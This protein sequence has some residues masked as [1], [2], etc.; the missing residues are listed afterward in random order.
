MNR[1]AHRLFIAM[2]VLSSFFCI[3]HYWY[4]EKSAC[5]KVAELNHLDLACESPDLIIFSYDRPMQLYALLESI[6]KHI[7]GFASIA[8][9]Y[10][11]S[12]H[13][14]GAGYD[15]VKNEFEKVHFMQQSGNGQ[16]DFK[17]LLLQAFYAGKSPYVCFGVDDIIVKNDVDL[18]NCVRAL[19]KHEAYGFYLRLGTHLTKCYSLHKDQPL[20]TTMA[21]IG[22]NMVA[23]TF[24]DGF[25]DWRYPNS[26]DMTIYSKRD[27]VDSCV[28]LDYSNPN[29]FEAS[30]AR[31]A[32]SIFDKKGLCFIDSIV[33]NIPINCVQ[34]VMKNRNMDQ[35]SSEQLQK[36]FDA[37][38][39]ID[40]RPLVAMRNESCHMPYSCTFVER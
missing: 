9:I 25:C 38:L 4:K 27:I 3:F 31:S 14:Y 30:W 36:M 11:S 23:W 8:I 40:I 29:S 28:R 37:G 19:K 5:I 2:L 10:R 35:W 33:V 6:K 17:T 12:N 15:R 24:K 39:K 16:S 32:S 7:V 18:R 1:I 34:S 13:D 20:P 26:V 22:D 21:P